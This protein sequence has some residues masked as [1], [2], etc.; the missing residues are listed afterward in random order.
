MLEPLQTHEI[1]SLAKPA[2]R[3]KGVAG[4]PLDEADIEHARSWGARLSVP[5][6]PALLD[7]LQRHP[8]TDEDKAQVKRWSSLYGLRF[9][10]SAGLDVAYDGEQQR[11]EMYA[12][13]I[14]HAH[15]F[16]FRGNVRSFDNKYY[17]KAAVTG[18][19]ALATPYHNEEYRLLRDS[20]RAALKIPVTGP[21]TLAAWSFDEYY[22][23]GAD[24]TEPA[25]TRRARRREARR[26]FVLDV[27]EQLV[28]P[29]IEALIDSGARWIQIDEPAGSTDP[30]EVALMGAAF[31]A[32]VKGLPGTFS[33]HLCFSDYNLFF[34]GLEDMTECQQY[35][36]GF[37]NDDSRDLGVTAEARPGYQV[38]R[39]FRDL[40]HQ[41]S[42][43]LGVLDIHSDEI[44]SPELVRDRVLYAVEVF[45]D[46]ARIQVTPDCGLRTRTWE[47]SYDKLTNMVAGVKLAKRELGL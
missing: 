26:R 15:G 13:T 23:R 28:R 4:Q 25:G 11:S 16:E 14:R 12:W 30:D 42:L 21:Y 39:K 34:P 44:E 31:D 35:A 36:V 6:Y 33:T 3:V 45:G 17:S 20:A 19:I 43:G 27:A 40:P 41:P 10:E 1:G 8:L 5:D 22:D 24:V 37:A 2:W 29:N 38:I 47:V 9:F 18:P 7:L 32:C 46:P